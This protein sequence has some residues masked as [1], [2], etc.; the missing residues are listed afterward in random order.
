M[1][2]VVAVLL[3]PFFP[4]LA[5]CNG[6][7]TSSPGPAQPTCVL[8]PTGDVYDCVAPLAG[9]YA[10]CGPDAGEGAP[11]QGNNPAC[12]SCVGSE[13]GNQTIVCTCVDDG[14]FQGDANAQSAPSWSCEATGYLCQ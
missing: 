2:P 11:C 13:L 7:S 12:V 9:S 1:R 3:V 10:E 5:G 6:S 14:G 4:A 8:Q